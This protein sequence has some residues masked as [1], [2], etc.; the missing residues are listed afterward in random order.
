MRTNSP[1]TEEA[2]Q[3]ARSKPRSLAFER[4]V[5]FVAIRQSQSGDEVLRQLLLHVGTLPSGATLANAAEYTGQVEELF[6]LRLPESRVQSALDSLVS[7]RDLVRAAKGPYRLSVSVR[8]SILQRVAESRE[9]EKRVKKQWL[10]ISCT[11]H[12]EVDVDEAWRALEAYLTSA[13]RSHGIQTIALLDPTYDAAEEHQNGLRGML[14]EAVERECSP[15]QQPIV[16]ECILEFLLN[17]SRNVDRSAF[18][19]RLA[20]A[21]EL[22]S[23]SV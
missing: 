23:R 18:I 14:A 9:L 16:K 5:G 8:A 17:A 20:D 4:F 22:M 6:G 1:Y 2:R 7:K 3:S 21:R 11:A 12:P 15:T 10:E 19:A 13:F